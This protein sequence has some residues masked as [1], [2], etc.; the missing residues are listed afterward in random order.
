M[1]PWTVA[2]QAPLFMGFSRE[3]YWS[4]LPFFS[5]GGLPDPGMEAGS[6]TLKAY[7]YI[8]FFFFFFFGKNAKDLLSAN[9][10][11]TIHYYELW[12]LYYML[13]SSNLFI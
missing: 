11:Y 5:P 7:I 4:G 1:P 13:E 6:L 8:Y 10:K 9:F 12:S 3:E 2:H